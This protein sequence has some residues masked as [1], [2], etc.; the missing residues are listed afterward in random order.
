MN[1]LKV[2]TMILDLLASMKKMAD[3]L[4]PHSSGRDA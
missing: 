1:K 4:S 2:N 3:I